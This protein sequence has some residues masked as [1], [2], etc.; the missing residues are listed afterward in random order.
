MADDSGIEIDYL[1]GQL[2]IYS[3]RYAKGDFKNARFKI[4]KSLK[5]I[6]DNQRT[7]RFV[8]VIALFNPKTNNLKMFKGE[9]K[10]CLKGV[11]TKDVP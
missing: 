1:K 10:G 11:P 3:N 7:A 2:G 5:N 9:S 4:L 6:P 8:C